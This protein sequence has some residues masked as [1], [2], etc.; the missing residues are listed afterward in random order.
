MRKTRFLAAIVAV[1]TLISVI[2]AMTAF[3]ADDHLVAHYTF[4]D[5]NNLL[6]AAIGKD[7]TSVGTLKAAEGKIGGAVSFDGAAAIHVTDSGITNLSAVTIS[8]W[9]KPTGIDPEK[10]DAQYAFV[11]ADGWANQGEVHNFIRNNGKCETDVGDLW[12]QWKSQKPSEKMLANDQWVLLTNVFDGAANKI[13]TYFNGE[14]V[15]TNETNDGVLAGK[16]MTLANFT[17]GAFTNNGESGRYYKGLMD[18]VRI[19]DKALSA[20]EV[21]ALANNG[22]EES[23]STFDAMTAMTVVALIPAAAV[24][25]GKKRSFRAGK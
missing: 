24:V 22:G 15:N 5:A 10:G 16:P 7:G 18:D 4:D 25:F 13:Y 17:I 3:A 14:L 11:T 19:Y 6:K 8:A 20:N 12:G 21:A 9:I 2:P 23:P 1:L